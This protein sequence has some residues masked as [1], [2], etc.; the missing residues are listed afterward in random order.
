MTNETELAP[1]KKFVERFKARMLAVAGPKFDD[2]SSIAEY[3][4]MTAP[5][6]FEDRD[7]ET[8]E[9]CADAGDRDWETFGP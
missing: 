2:G 6:Y 5:T 7:G 3:A 9:E 4:E 8:P 1:I